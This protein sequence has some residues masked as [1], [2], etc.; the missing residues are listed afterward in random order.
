MQS[1][2][3]PLVGQDW[4]ESS[5]KTRAID[6]PTRGWADKT[7]SYHDYPPSELW[8]NN[9]GWFSIYYWT[10]IRNINSD[11]NPNP[12]GNGLNFDEL[13]Q[14]AT[15]LSLGKVYFKFKTGKGPTDLTENTFKREVR[16]RNWYAPSYPTYYVG[17]S[18]AAS[19]AI[20]KTGCDINA[21]YSRTANI[22]MQAYALDFN[23]VTDDEACKAIEHTE[24]GAIAVGT[25]EPPTTTAP[26]TTTTAPTTTTTAPTTTTTAPTTTTTAPTTT[27]TAP[28]TTA[29]APTTTTTAPTTTTTAPTTTTIPTTQPVK[30]IFSTKYEQ[31]FW[32]WFKFIVL[33]GWIWMWF[34]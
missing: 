24:L 4:P 8:S 15:G 18:D 3:V 33:F 16:A 1:Y 32:N 9:N 19:R 14:P 28:T 30:T 10:Q 31:N 12:S 27:T 6:Y 23:V 21:Y 29:T 5:N 26:T 17:A 2:E 7:T 20:Y 13:L 22:G 34:I 25:T 11:F